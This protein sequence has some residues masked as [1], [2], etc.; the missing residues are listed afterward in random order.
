[1]LK[2][3]AA[4]TEVTEGAN[5][6]C[7]TPGDWFLVNDHCQR[8]VAYIGTR[9]QIDQIFGIEPEISVNLGHDKIRFYP[10]EL[11]LVTKAPPP[12]PFKKGD[13]VLIDIDRAEVADPQE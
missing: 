1:M 13:L 6:F 5:S 9:G 7:F 11:T 10:H 2:R 12:S 4:D 8:L 3:K